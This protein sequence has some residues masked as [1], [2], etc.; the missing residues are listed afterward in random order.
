MILVYMT[1][2]DGEPVIFEAEKSKVADRIKKLN[3]DWTDYALIEG[4][5]IKTFNQK[6]QI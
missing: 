5:I 1:G 2:T 3:L 4:T 6:K